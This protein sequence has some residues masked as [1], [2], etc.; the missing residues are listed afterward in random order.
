[1]SGRVNPPCFRER[2]EEWDR[3]RFQFSEGEDGLDSL[4]VYND[5]FSRLEAEEE[6]NK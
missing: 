2:I 3:P 1:M 5:P 4:C 6:K